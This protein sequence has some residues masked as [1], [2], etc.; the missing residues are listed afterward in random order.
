MRVE[1]SGPFV[2]W[3][4]GFRTYRE[5]CTLITCLE[6]SKHLV[7]WTRALRTNRVTLHCAYWSSDTTEHFVLCTRA[8]GTYRSLRAVITL[9]CGYMRLEH[10]GPFVLWIHGFR[11]YRELCTVDTYLEHTKHFVLLTRALRTNR[12]TL[13]CA[14]WSSNITEHFVL[15]TRAFGTY[16]SLR[17]VYVWIRNIL[18]PLSNVFVSPFVQNI[19]NTY[20][21]GYVRSQCP[22]TD[23]LSCVYM[24]SERTEQ[25]VQ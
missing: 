6:R 21:C 19:L 8:F 7:L 22:V 25:P 15:C 16:R 23:S 5:L 13:H 1:D 4:H 17:T 14:Y 24:R 3:I 12:V 18:N 9:S 20:C 10:S 11:T 2:L